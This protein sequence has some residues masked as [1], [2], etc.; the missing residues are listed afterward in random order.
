ML[1]I[2][3]VSRTDELHRVLPDGCLDVMWTGGELV[4]AGPDTTAQVAVS[5][6]GTSFAALR[7][8]PGLG[9][10]ILGVPAHELRNR[11]VPLAALWPSAQVRDLS[12]Q[13][14]AATDPT[15]LLESVAAGRF[16]TTGRADPV[17]AAVA[18]RLGAGWSVAATASAVN[19]SERQL[20]RRC[21]PAFG[22]GP[23]TL[24]RVLR[25]GRAL[26]LARAGTPAATVAATTGYAD[27][28]HLAREVRTLAGVTLRNLIG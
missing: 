16:R 10:E 1:W 27:Q 4:V 23:K 5:P 24:A 19:L 17:V 13:L 11:R 12:E 21:L 18:A 26:D 3:D 8:G 9:P 15:R 22:Y 25:L 14:A 6:A 20:H 28:A 7:F 2:R